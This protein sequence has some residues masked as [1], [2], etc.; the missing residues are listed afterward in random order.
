M[1][2][3][4]LAAAFA[5]GLIYGRKARAV[6]VF[7]PPKIIYLP[8][9]KAGTVANDR[10]PD[11]EEKLRSMNFSPESLSGVIKRAEELYGLLQEREKCI[12]TLFEASKALNERRI[13]PS[14][15]RSITRRWLMKLVEI[16]DSLK[17]REEELRREVREITAV[18]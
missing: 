4:T 7:V 12:Q 11:L 5:L 13:S 17:A 8:L 9:T 1:T 16:E 2:G 6:K 15:Y 18:R 3:V 10:L 14:T